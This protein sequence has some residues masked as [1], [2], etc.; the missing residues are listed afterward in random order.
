MAILKKIWPYLSVMAAMLVFVL[1]WFLGS[2]LPPKKLVL[3]A[4]VEGGAYHAAAL[5]YQALLARDGVKVEVRTSAGAIENLERLLDAK[6]EHMIGFVQ[7]GLLKQADE[8]EDEDS[9]KVAADKTTL[10]SVGSM[11][12][13]PVWIFVR[14]AHWP[15]LKSGMLERVTDLA[16]ARVSIGLPRSGTRQVALDLLRINGLG[17]GAQKGGVARQELSAKETAAALKAGEIDAAIM[18][19]GVKSA[20]IQDLLSAPG[21]ELM[22]LR[23]ADGYLRHM[24]SLTKL[25]LPQGTINFQKNLP[26]QDVTLL[27]T[28]ASIVMRSDE[29][30]A[31]A[32]LLWK[33]ARQI[34]EDADILHPAKAFPTLTQPQDFVVNDDVARLYKDG[35][36]FIYRYLPYWAA[37]L[38]VRLFVLLLPLA[39]IIFTLAD[40]LP[41]LQ[42]IY[43]RHR[44]FRHYRA[45]RDIEKRIKAAPDQVTAQALLGE[46]DQV[47]QQISQMR[48]PNGFAS[49]QFDVRDHIAFVRGRLLDTAGRRPAKYEKN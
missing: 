36:P 33:A 1:S 6:S 34:H 42:G 15:Q 38:L 43:I 9:D 46:L 2:P 13:E 32:Y 29:H 7:N 25:V 20:V 30:P 23:L 41:R 10:Q 5:Q 44:L 18:V 16:G 24:P 22:N 11:F 27:S 39:A 47:E 12:N 17:N 14:R 49:L 4:G 48:I 37:N 21:I 45:I 3:T 35:K 19:S 40:W 31:I 28:T 26:T 8:D